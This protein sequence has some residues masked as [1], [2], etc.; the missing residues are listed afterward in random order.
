MKLRL[1]AV[2]FLALLLALGLALAVAAREPAPEPNAA[3]DALPTLRLSLPADPLLD[4]DLITDPESNFVA[5]QLFLGLVRAD[6]TTG[7][8]MPELATAWEM[9]PGA[10]VFTFTLRSGLT[11]T[12]GNPLTAYDV[13]YGILRSLD[14]DTASELAYMLFW[15]RNAEEYNN[16]TVTDP[17]QVGVAVLD[18]THL[19]FDLRQPAAFF[20]STLAVPVAKPMPQWAINAHP[21]DWTEPAHIVTSGA[22]RLAAWSHGSSLALEQNPGYYDAGT[23]QIG[24]VSFSIL[25]EA[26]AWAAYR[27]GLLDSAIVPMSEWNAA[28]TDPVVSPQLHAASQPGTY[29]YGFN[30][31]KAPFDNLLVRKAF[32]A[33]TD[34][35]GIVELAAGRS[36]GRTVQG[37]PSALTFTPPGMWGHTDGAGEGV[38]IPYDPVQARQWLAAAGYPNGQGLPP[39]TLMFDSR[40]S[41]ADLNL[42][43]ASQMR[44]GWLDEL[45]ASVTVTHTEWADYLELL[46]T[47]APQVWQLRWLADYR[48]AY[49]FLRDG[50]DSFG[51]AN[52][53]GWTNPTYES[54]LDLAARTMDL[55]ERASLYKQAEEILVE[56]DGVMA[57]VFYW[58]TGVAAGPHLARTYGN[59]G[60]AG[61]IA[62]WLINWRVHLPLALKSASSGP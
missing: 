20:P 62:E 61:R 19:R 10:S 17:N 60:W 31:A 48:D 55:N 40:S 9:S 36:D 45:G 16:G 13:R 21:G 56:T 33:A 39:I 41:F 28:R 37:V 7:A 29:Y 46:R 51:R 54:L 47:D 11:W 22:Y 23:V 32:V 53:G 24:Q 8:P 4:P 12:D 3:E 52:Y 18:Y 38:G 5:D 35:E 42:A 30:K 34:R 25:G 2:L 27:A 26:A 1:A 44:Q 15:I 57:P 6:E 58:A 43:I 49:N 59:G 14:P 50:V